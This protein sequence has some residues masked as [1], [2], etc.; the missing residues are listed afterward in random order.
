MEDGDLEFGGGVGVDAVI[1]FDYN[2]P[3][4]V[5]ATAAVVG[6]GEG[7]GG[8]AEDGVVEAGGD[9]AKSASV[10]RESC[11]ET[12]GIKARG[13]GRVLVDDAEVGEVVE[14]LDL[15]WG[16]GCFAVGLAEFEA[17]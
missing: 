8:R 10:G 3:F 14:H 15:G 2:K 1:C 17:A 7:R 9:T 6:G 16:Q 4:S 12:G 11:R 5:S 13:R